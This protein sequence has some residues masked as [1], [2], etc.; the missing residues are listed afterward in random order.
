MYNSV[1]LVFKK[2]VVSQFF[3]KSRGLWFSTS[4]YQSVSSCPDR[5][6]GVRGAAAVGE[7]S[8]GAGEHLQ[9]PSAHLH[10]Q[11]KPVGLC[12]GPK[13]LVRGRGIQVD[14]DATIPG[15]RQD[16]TRLKAINSHK[17]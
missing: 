17:E 12:R 8:P 1:A 13:V 5:P 2:T 6:P 7:W 10:P 15:Q 9:G 16:V 3:H 4:A 11:R 14:R